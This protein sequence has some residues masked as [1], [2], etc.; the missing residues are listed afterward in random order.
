[1]SNIR[2]GGMLVALMVA[3]AAGAAGNTPIATPDVAARS[4]LY[5]LQFWNTLTQ[6]VH[7]FDIEARQVI[8]RGFGQLKT[9]TTVQALM[10]SPHGVVVACPQGGMLTARM[11]RGLPRIAR[12]EWSDCRTEDAFGPYTL[13]GPAEATLLEASFTPSTLTASAWET[14]RANWCFRGRNAR[15][16]FLAKASS[17]AICA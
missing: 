1:M 10:A 4:A 8:E 14:R 2:I 7:A 3:Q 5:M 16:R 11:S 13:N 6:Q 15:A 17:I 9:A 12:F